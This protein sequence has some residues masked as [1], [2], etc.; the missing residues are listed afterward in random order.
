ME[1]M[2]SSYY[3]NY[4]HKLDFEASPK[5]CLLI[6][7]VIKCSIRHLDLVFAEDTQNHI[8][9]KQFYSL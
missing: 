4:S 9:L 2:Y 8:C 3:A 5:A 1:E 7:I 6:S